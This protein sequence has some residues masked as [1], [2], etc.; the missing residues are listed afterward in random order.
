ME[1]TTFNINL[2]QEIY[3][4]KKNMKDLEQNILKIE[5]IIQF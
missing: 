1:N 5:D 3:N 2:E 4:L